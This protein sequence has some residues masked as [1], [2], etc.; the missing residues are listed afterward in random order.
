MHV[1]IEGH[2]PFSIADED[3]QR[4]T[5]LQRLH[6]AAPNQAVPLDT[7]VRGLQDWLDGPERCQP[8]T[9]EQALDGIEVRET[10]DGCT[11]DA[12]CD[13]PNRL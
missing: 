11:Y 5:L 1:V 3:V 2:Q 7:S 4:S 9:F 6:D 10:I 12:A 13:F 8:D